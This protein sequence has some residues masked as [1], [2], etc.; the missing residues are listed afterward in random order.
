MRAAAT[1]GRL[2]PSPTNRMTFLAFPLSAPR[3]AACDAP[4]RNHH[5]AVWPSGRWTSGTATAGCGAVAAM[6]AGAVGMAAQAPSN[7]VVMQAR[8]GARWRRMAI[9]VGRD[10]P[11]SLARGRAVRYLRPMSHPEFR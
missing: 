2:M 8:L 1:V 6:V 10:R 7:A 9:L 5:S 11:L 3:A 4:L